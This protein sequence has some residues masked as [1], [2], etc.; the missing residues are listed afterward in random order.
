M[1]RILLLFALVGLYVSALAQNYDITYHPMFDSTMHPFNHGVA[2][3]DSR[4]D[5]FVIWTRLT[6]KKDV[7]QLKVQWFVSTSP[8][9]KDVVK[10]GE[11]V[12]GPERD[13]TVKVLVTGLKPFTQYYYWFRVCSPFKKNDCHKSD[14]GKVKTTPAPDQ[15]VKELSFAVFTGSNYNAGYF[16]AYCDVA[17]RNDLDFAIHTGDYI[18]EYANNVYGD[19]PDRWLIPKH[20]IVKLEDYRRRYS[21]YR[22]D[23]CLRKAHE[24]LGWYTIWDDHEV[25]NDAWKAGAEN[26]QP[27]KEGDFFV[28]RRNAFQA[29]FE[30][31]PIRDNPDTSVIRAFPMGK[32]AYFIF[33]DTRNTGR[34]FQGI[35][36]F[37]PNKT[38]LGK[39]QLDW[40][41]NQLLEAKK[42]GYD[43][44]VVVQQLM[45]APLIL[46]GDTINKDGW[47]MYVMERR[48]I[49]QFLYDNDIKNV[50][51][52]G[53]DFHTSWVDELYLTPEIYSGRK[54]DT[55]VAIEFVT[56]SVTSEN[57][58]WVKTL[59]G[60]YVSHTKKYNYIRYVDLHHKGYMVLRLYPDKVVAEYYYVKTI[61]KPNKKVKLHKRYIYTGLPKH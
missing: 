21:H 1:K 37:D 53:G 14:I 26:H 6:P 35:N 47:D 11:F 41:F 23:S 29:Y 44:I 17:R 30:W 19:N 25:A 45:M 16:N 31:L 27:D 20:E 3:G 42:G 32:L 4:D 5:G 57:A 8:D 43:W 51:F 55:M 28:R 52:V 12:T 24:A 61:E 33:L 38:M 34:D 39:E 10:S 46:G 50:V 49:L 48:K 22:L 60:K 15:E 9:E 36:P 56:P 7:K 40:F 2:A 59:Y 58:N 54:K 13:Y 18:Y